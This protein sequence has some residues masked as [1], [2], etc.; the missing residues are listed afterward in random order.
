M[1]NT[2]LA[3]LALV[4]LRSATVIAVFGAGSLM[5]QPTVKTW[6]GGASTTHFGYVD[7][8]TLMSFFHTPMGM[9][10]SQ[11]GQTVFVA[12]RDNNAVRLFTDFQDANNGWTFTFTTN[13]ISKPVG[14]ALDAAGD[15]YVLNRG[16]TNAIATNGTV[17]EFDQYGYFV[18]TNAYGLT[19]AAGMALDPFGNI[20]V[21]E[22]SNLLVEI[23][24][25]NNLN[26]VATVNL[27]TNVSLQ[28]IS[29]MP[30]GTIAA[31]DSGR[32]G[33]YIITPNVN[34][35]NVVITQIAGFN[36]QG[37][38]TG[39]NNQG[40]PTNRA[41]FFQPTGVAAASD[42]TLIVSDFGNGHVKVITTSG[43]VTNFYGVVSNDWKSAF[44]GW[45]DGLVA[46]PDLPGGVAGRC[47][48]AVALS[49]DGT[50]VWTTEDFYHTVRR[51]TGQSFQPPVQPIP[52][53]PTGFTATLV[54]NGNSFQVDLTWN[55]VVNASRYGVQRGTSQSGPFNLLQITSGTSYIDTNVAPANTY[56]YV[57]EAE[58]SG[59]VS[60]N[61]APVRVIIPAI[62]PLQP[63]IGWYDFPVANG[64]L[65]Q[66]H[67]VAPGIP[68]IANNPLNIGV[69]QVDTN[70]PQTYYITIPPQTN[71]TTFSYVTNY[72]QAPPVY[73]DNN[74]PG[75]NVNSLYPQLP[76]SL[77]S[78]GLVTIEAVNLDGNHVPSAVTSA[79]FLFQVGPISLIGTNAAQFNLVDVTTNLT[80]YYT[81]DGSDPL[82]NA[83][84]QQ[85]TT[86]SNTTPFSILIS[87][88]FTFEVVGKRSGYAPS[89]TLKYTFLGQNFQVTTLSWGFE[90]GYCSSEFIG[91]PGEMFY[92][93]VTII[94]LPGTVMYGLEFNMTVTNL[95][96]DAVPSGGFGFQSMLQ[97][98]VTESNV[99][100]VVFKEIPPYMFIGVASSP[101]PP[102]Q[103]VNYNGTNFV[104]LEVANT[105]LN[106]L[107]VGWF[108]VALHTN[109]Y[110]TA[111]QNLLT[112][113][114]AFVEQIPNQEFPNKDIVGGYAF[115][116]PTNAQPGEQYQIQLNRASANGDGLGGPNS[117]VPI[118]L[119]LTGSLTNGAINAI[120]IVTVGQP[121]YLAGDIYPFRW[122]NAGDFG[123]GSLTNYGANDVMATFNWAVYGFNEPAPGSDFYDAMDSAG[124]LG[125]YNAAAGYWV[126]SG[127]LS[128]AALYPMYDPANT[129]AINQ[130]AFGDGTIDV[131]DIFV[132]F[133][134][135][136][137]GNLNWFQRFYTNDPVHG[138]F[139]RVAQAIYPQTNAFGNSLS[140]QPVKPGVKGA[141]SSQPV[142]ITNT[143]SV[144]FSATDF[145][146][147]AGQTLTIP[148]N[149][150]TFG[151]YPIRM[152][153]LNVSVVPLDGSPALTTAAQFTP[154][155]ALAT[156][157]GNQ[158]P[159]L[160]TNQGPGNYAAVWLPSGALSQ[161][162]GLSA[163]ANIGYVTVTIPANATSSSAYAIHFD[164]ASAS[165]SGLAS[166][167]RKTL[168][169]LITLSNRSSSYYGDGIPD[170]WRLRYF[171]TIYNEL[172]VSNA[173][174][175]G[176][177]M[178]NYQKYVAGLD[179]MDPTSVLNA[180]TDQT[181]AQSPQDHVVYWP[182]VSGQTYVI[183]R[184]S[185]L[186]PPKWTPVATAIGDGSYME[187]HDAPG[188]DNYF[189][190]VTTH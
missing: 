165:P 189:Y 81:T 71:N 98:P 135:S 178:N 82:T 36:G 87:S 41:K 159:L 103:I 66:L 157:F 55:S 162:P 83:N 119:P 176:T 18:M 3:G 104:N 107:A 58:N 68:Y 160:S 13:F 54:T 76:L 19:N 79:T 124:G 109:L 85:F 95:G 168:T 1:K 136:Q 175:D 29:M 133:E 112:Y 8:N 10:V 123:W 38:G 111:A 62:P 140:F 17:L 69:A 93:P 150:T 126:P 80:Y 27:G 72:G 97:K 63:A 164:H 154:S 138:V 127:T 181:M 174:A 156:A 116:V 28:G 89:P 96:A 25:G 161:L 6:G 142:S 153:A 158:A 171:G 42:G 114:E 9:A 170:S 15:V 78:N 99:V 179:P 35:T 67:P 118:A 61:T 101:P 31:C 65:S 23:T 110:N 151:P 128:G 86:I 75:A 129:G 45:V 169:G 30:N 147:S 57:V 145:L 172:S 51:V 121:K 90:S 144:N 33:I 132:T 53:T 120:K 70:G 2:N 26:T 32:N 47:Q 115:Q 22:R 148:I 122:F 102:N 52:A 77:M 88:N 37:D 105:N 183:E 143:P 64:F 92:A 46:V 108:E 190:R 39:I 188:G 130:M 186:F 139:G 185:T 117:A 59:G 131:C 16:S 43:I 146:A 60:P 34:P 14:V 84:A 137:F 182:S 40:L 7:T 106:E 5:A 100:G 173:D 125:T 134:R 24:G 11:N 163:N 49:P 12:D 152:L 180:G 177:G 73:K 74:S 4:A 149:A 20:Y 50:T 56:Y 141:V 21:T 187:I 91:S 113:S 94:S 48:D 44:P 155:P 166:L 184:S 167:P